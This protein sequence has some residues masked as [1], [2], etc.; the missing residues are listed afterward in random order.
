[1]LALMALPNAM[2]ARKKNQSP[3]L[4]GFLSILAFFL[5]YVFVGGA[6]FSMVYKGAMTQEAV[7]A[8]V[9]EKPLVALMMFLFGIGGILLMRFILERK[10]R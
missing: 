4:W 1:M 2:L 5:T 10:K 8:W 6:Y 7:S 3:L 9:M